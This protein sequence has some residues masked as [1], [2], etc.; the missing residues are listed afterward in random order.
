MNEPDSLNAILNLRQHKWPFVMIAKYASITRESLIR[1]H[2]SA[3]EMVQNNELEFEKMSML[4]YGEWKEQNKGL[5]PISER[6]LKSVMHNSGD[7][8][9]AT[10]NLNALLLTLYGIGYSLRDIA[11]S[12]EMSAESVR[13]RVIEVRNEITAETDLES[14]V[15]RYSHRFPSAKFNPSRV[16]KLGS[17]SR[18]V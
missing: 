6:F 2:N 13:S 9:V 16:T 8:T 14:A 7:S 5:L 12:A 11:H 10:Y 4:S 18:T 3:S 17:D 1:R 15:E